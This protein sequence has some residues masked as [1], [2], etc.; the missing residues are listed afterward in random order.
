MRPK[1][2]RLEWLCHCAIQPKGS[3]VKNNKK[4][5]TARTLVVGLGEVG[6]ALVQVLE[7]TE[8]VLKHDLARCDFDQPIGVMHLCYPYGSGERFEEI[9]LSYIERFKPELTIINS[10]VMP[11]TTRSIA[12]RS[13]QPV[14]FSPVRGKHIRMAEDLLHY[15]KFVAG[16]DPATAA[17]AEMHFH[18]AGMQTRRISKPETLELAKL[19]ETSYF[20]VIIAFAQEL[21]RYAA[22][23]GAN[24]DEAATF[25]DEIGYLPQTRYFPGFIGGHCVIPNIRL[26]L[27]MAPAALLQAVLDSN[28]RRA[29]EL[30]AD[31]P[32]H[33]NRQTNPE[34]GARSK[35]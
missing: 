23:L 11:G 18:Q 25:F 10:T 33:N 30:S 2:Q 8:L 9:A 34:I 20:G 5:S 13:R 22:A 6:G 1:I 7:R 26:L 28:R 19:A 4:R 35:G 3:P 24:Y 31:H 17:R 21:N 32:H 15:K 29:R 27:R 12:D 14:V 16:F